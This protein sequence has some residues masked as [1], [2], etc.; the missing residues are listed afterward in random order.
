MSVELNEEALVR[1]LS[2]PAGAVGQ[3][4]ERRALAV[5]NAQKRLLSLHGSG[6]VYTTTF[7]T[8]A[9]GRLR[10]GRARVPHQASAPGEPP[11]VDTGLLRASI[12]H[13]VATDAE[14]L[15]AEIGS[16]GGVAPGVKY[17]AYLELGTSKMEPRPYLRPS[18]DA[19]RE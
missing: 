10:R 14:G 4:L 18:I 12:G 2:D 9:R 6:R 13:T 5:E 19:A 15:Y 16:G 3:D 7:W 8:D 11:A 17:A 1:L